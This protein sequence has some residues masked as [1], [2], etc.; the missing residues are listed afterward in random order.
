MSPRKEFREVTKARVE[1]TSPQGPPV[2]P[3]DQ[4]GQRR[5][6]RWDQEEFAEVL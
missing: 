5:I 3:H 2:R 4:C 1:G 6:H